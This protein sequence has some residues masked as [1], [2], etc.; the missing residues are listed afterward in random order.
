MG[1][2]DPR[3]GRRPWAVVQLRQENLRAESFNLVGFQN[4]LK[5]GEQARILRM[6]P[7]LEK[8]EFLRFGQIHRNTYINAPA[9]LTPTLQLRTRPE[10]FFAGQ[11]SGVE[12]YVESIATGLMAGM[13]AAA[14]AAGESPRALPRE[15]ALGSLCHYVSG[16]DPKNYQPANITFDLLPQLDEA[17]RQRLRRDKKARH[18]EVCRRALDAFAA[19]L[20]PIAMPASEL[21]RQIE[22]YL[23]E[24]ARAGNS[25]AHHSRL[26]SRPA[27]VSGSTCRLRSWRRPSRG[28]R[29]ADCFASG[30]PRSTADELTAV[31]IRRKLAAVRGLFRFMLREGVV[32]INVA[33]P[34]AH[35][36]GAA[37][38]AGGDDRGAGQR[39]DRWR[40]RRQTG[41]SVSGAR[42]RHLRTALRLRRARERTGGPE[43]GRSRPRRAMAAGARQGQEGAP[44]AA[45]REGRRSAGTLPRRTSGGARGARGLSEPSRPAPDHARHLAASSSSTRRISTGDPSIHPHSFRHAYATHLLADGADLRAIQEL[46]GHARLSTTQKYTQVSLTDLMAV[47]DKAHPKA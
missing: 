41:A 10:V 45:S 35:A 37:E 25:A 46:L 16:A 24:L 47:Y 34:G 27:P 15:T 31:T 5:F 17:D 22:R 43:P 2:D 39:A 11:I 32:P 21:E 13:H 42:P 18:A 6:I 7:G 28:D 30:W 33:A 14:L 29:S 20:E 8:A 1:L 9:L 26:R 40:G 19:Y 38:T 44:G 12:G 3:T 36:E 4:H 23:E